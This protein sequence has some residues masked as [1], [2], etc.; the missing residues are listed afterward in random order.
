M[1][2]VMS[3]LLSL[4]PC[5]WLAGTAAAQSGYTLRSPGQKIEMR[6]RTAGRIQY[7]VLVN[8]KILLQN[9]TMS[10]DIDRNTLGRDMKVRATKE[11]SNDQVIAPPIRQK[12][13]KIRDRYNELRIDAE[14]GLSVVFRAYD[15]GVA[16]RL[17][18]SLPTPE[19]KV[20]GEEA[21]FNFADNYTVFYPQEDSFFSH[22]ERQYLPHKLKEIAPAAIASLPAVVDAGGV[23]VAI[24]ESDVEDYPGMWLR[25]SGGNSRAATFP[26]YPLKETLERDRDY[27]VTEAAGYIAATRGQRH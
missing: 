13:A 23:K 25:G 10:I 6:I 20:I 1:N 2:C 5:L 18:T 3:T 14:G 7:D 15:E 27:K 24:A 11:R 17:E 16:Y 9:S 21:N 4:A 19:V 8:G 22:N 12:F 26:P